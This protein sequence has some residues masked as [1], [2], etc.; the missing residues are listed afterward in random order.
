MTIYYFFKLSHPRKD[1]IV[2][3]LQ[4]LS[5][6]DDVDYEVILFNRMID[7]ELGQLEKRV[8]AKSM[9]CQVSDHGLLFSGLIQKFADIV[10][11]RIGGLVD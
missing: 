3:C 6:S 1:A 2:G 8:H 5:A 10:V 11:D 4:V 9:E 7:P